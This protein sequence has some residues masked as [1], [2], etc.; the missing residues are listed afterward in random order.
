M[1]S[2]GENVGEEARKNYSRWLDG[3]FYARYLSGEN[4]LD[5]GYS[6]YLDGVKP[7]TPSAIGVGLDYPGYD[8]KTLPFGDDSQDAVFASHCL[9]HIDDYRSAIR[10]WFRVVRVGGH[11]VVSVPHQYLYER[12]LHLPSQFN[13]D[14]RRFYTA[15]SLLSEVEEAVDPIHFRVRHL[16]DNDRGFDYSIPPDR[17]AVGSYEILLVIEKIARPGYADLVSAEPEIT[18]ASDGVFMMIPK[19]GNDR[20]VVAV[21][22]TAPPQSVIV[23]KMDHLGDFIAAEPAMSDLRTAFPEAHLTLVCGSWNVGAAKELGVFDEVI[24]FSLF[25]RYSPLNGTIDLEASVEELHRLVR[26]REFDLALDLRV[27]PDTRSVLKHVNA[28]VR[29]GFGTKQSFPW[30]D[31]ALPMISPNFTIVQPRNVALVELTPRPQIRTSRSWIG[32]FKV[33]TTPTPAISLPGPDARRSLPPL[34]TIS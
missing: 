12:R 10:E 6:G 13:A 29:A 31:I 27:D 26:D 14:H 28:R 9:E 18:T 34:Q 30:L 20:P 16:E 1:H 8:G 24:E 21:S 4:V 19:P 7:I 17:H 32:L 22:S 33:S 11:L 23:F 25:A 2:W 3:G 15:A 5:I